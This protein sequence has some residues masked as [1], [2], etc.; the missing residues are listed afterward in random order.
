VELLVAVE[1]VSLSQERGLGLVVGSR[2]L[3]ITPIA[4]VKGSAYF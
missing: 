3:S 1:G 2:V 4:A